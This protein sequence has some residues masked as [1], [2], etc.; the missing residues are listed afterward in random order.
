MKT[1]TDK[2]KEIYIEAK[3]CS[4]GSETKCPNCENTF[5]KIIH[6]QIFC[7]VKCKNEY[8]RSIRKSKKVRK[9]F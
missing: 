7:S 8:N 4:V 3:K 5:K 1:I 6:N 9:Y 2:Q